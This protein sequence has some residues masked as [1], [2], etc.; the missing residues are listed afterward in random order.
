MGLI[1]SQYCRN[2]LLSPLRNIPGPLW[3]SLTDYWLVTVDLAGL[4]TTVIHRLHRTYGPVVRIG[5]SEVS[6]A[7]IESVNQIYSQKTVFMKAPIYDSMSVK[8]PGIFS[9]RNKQ[10]HS[11]RRSVLS[12]AFSQSSVAACVP[13]IRQHVQSLV[14]LVDKASGKPVDVFLLFRLFALDVVGE[15]SLLQTH[16]ELNLMV[17]A[18]GN[19]S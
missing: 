16:Q 8:P 11:A 1:P 5:P 6:F 7:D 17:S 9:L 13:L 15:I 18:Q 3:A 19:C 4:R 10:A 2:R 14:D 12:H